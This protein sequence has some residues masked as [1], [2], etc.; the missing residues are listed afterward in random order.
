MGRQFA[1]D[2]TVVT[3]E[4]LNS[5]ANLQLYTLSTLYTPH[6]RPHSRWR[7]T[8]TQ[9]QA[10]FSKSYRDFSKWSMILG[11]YHIP[12]ALPI[13]QSHIAGTVLSSLPCTHLEKLLPLPR[14]PVSLTPCGL[15]VISF[16]IHRQLLIISTAQWSAFYCAVVSQLIVYCSVSSFSWWAPPRKVGI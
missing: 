9:S 4:S 16:A 7:S 6:P 2:H 13:H 14:S 11:T 3:L 15:P 8:E 1:R 12:C 10:T 5:I